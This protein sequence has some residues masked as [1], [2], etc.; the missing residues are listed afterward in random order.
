MSDLRDFTG[1]NRK[2]TGNIGEK[3]S[4]GT[5]GER[6][7][8]F[9]GG[10]LRF[11]TSTNLMEYYSGTDWKPI[12]SPPT[13]NSFEV[14]GGA[15]VTTASVDNE[16]SGDFTLT[17]NGSLFDT[18]S[19]AV[20]LVGGAAETLNAGSTTRNSA[21]L[22]T[23][24]FTLS[25]IDGD[26]SPYTIKVTNGS[27]LAATLAD[28]ISNDSGAP[29]WYNSA[30]TT[31]VM[32]DASRA[33]GISANDLCGA[34]GGSSFSI[35]SGSLPSGL[36]INTSTGAITGTTT[37][38]GSDTTT[39]F[40]VQ[41]TGDE[42]TGT[43]QFKITVKAPAVTSYTS[44]GAFTFSVPSGVTAVKA[45]L[46][47]GGGAGG[48]RSGGGGGAGG[49]I[50]HPSFSVTP[51]GT[52]SGNVGTGGAGNGD[53]S[54][55]DN[56]VNSTFGTLTAIG[57]GGGDADASSRAG[58]SG[59]GGHYGN[60]GATGQQP[61]QP[62]DSGTY[63]YGNP[64]GSGSGGPHHASGGGGGAG[65]AAASNA[66]PADVGV[67][68]GQGRV[69]NTSGS[70]VTYAGGGGGGSFRPQSNTSGNGGPGGGGSGGSYPGTNSGPGRSGTNNRGGG[71]G[72]SRHDTS[73]SQGGPGGSGG[74][75]IVVISY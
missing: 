52:V 73:Q 33:A 27:G 19:A 41:A 54:P 59:G 30:D 61:S 70:P 26:N 50:D 56:G 21:N 75:G 16:G 32:Y 58:G 34:N 38:V 40:T 45:L 57:G 6:D 1:K 48:S 60:N 46:V 66:S 17:I 18:T 9:G 64:G 67:P 63:G 29:A 62:G 20:S 3:I 2:F 55:G 35:S 15:T 47:A 5:T 11:N 10:T 23:A 69:S 8:S 36:S 72:G 43:R 42:E 39:T 53:T 4:S 71:G 22:V 7:V 25:D 65:N 44:T 12:D 24:T 74:S 51:G 68:G 13:I 37:A 28:A 49:M 31:Y 14:N